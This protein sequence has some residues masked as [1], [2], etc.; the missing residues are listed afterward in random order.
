MPKQ[1]KD[2]DQ[3]ASVV[4]SVNVDHISSGSSQINMSIGNF[5]DRDERELLDE[6]ELSPAEVEKLFRE[7]YEIISSPT[8][9]TMSSEQREDMQYILE[10]LQVQIRRGQQSNKQ[11][12]HR[13]LHFLDDRVPE[14]SE[15]VINALDR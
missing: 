11:I 9:S 7:I 5:V 13:F 1:E 14:I 3:I 12:L 6:S 15:I 10:G 8:G 2:L 4:G